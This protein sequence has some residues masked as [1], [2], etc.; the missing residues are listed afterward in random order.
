M[1]T[2]ARRPSSGPC[3]RGSTATGPTVRIHILKWDLGATKLLGRGTTIL[4][5]VRWA[6][7]KRIDFKLDGAHPPGGEPPPEDRRDRRQARFLR[8][9]R[10][11]RVALGHARACGRRPRRKRPTTGRAYGP[12]HDAT[13]A[14]DGA[15][16]RALG[17]L[18]RERW[19]TAGGEA[20]PA[21]AAGSDPW[22]EA[23]E[24]MFRDVDVA[25]ART[26]GAHRSAA[27]G[28]R[29][30][31]AV[32]RHDPPRPA[33]RLCREP[34]LRLAGGRRGDRR[35]AGRARRPGVRPRQSQ[36]DAT[37]GSRRR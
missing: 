12:W 16:A 32:R 15:A 37:A 9:D 36:E 4:R 13:M 22:P 23:L 5:L 3:C 10:H 25:I 28:P 20:L 24:P 8:R 21:P 33:L 2:T 6:M 27:R 19:R 1:P 17:E 14:V 26:R 7:S 29:D 18:S 31:G 35:A 30:R 11:D 34:V